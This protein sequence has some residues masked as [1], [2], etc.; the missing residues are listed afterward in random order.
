MQ[1]NPFPLRLRFAARF[2]LL[3]GFCVS[4]VGF[5]QAATPREELLRLVP[6]S[7]GFCLVVQDLRKHAADWQSSPFVEQ[8]RQCPIAVK[9]RSSDKWEKLNQI[10]SE[11]KAKLGLDWKQLRDDI[12]GDAVVLAYR[13]GSPGQPQQ[14]QGVMLLRARNEKVLADLIERVNKVQKE[15]GEL[16]DLT[17]RRHNGV[18]YY[19]RL[20]YDKCT[21]RAPA[22]TLYA[23]HGPILALSAQEDMIRQVIKGDTRSSGGISGGTGETPVQTRDRRDAGPTVSEAERRL[24]ELDAERALL[25][26]WLNPRAFDAEVDAKVANAPA[27]R[28]AAVKQF[29][30][31]WK[32]LESVVFSLS[33]QERDIH[34]SLGVRAR[35]PELPPAARRLFRE[36]ATA[37]DVW[38]RLPQSALFAAGGRLDGAAVLDVLG[39][40]LTP[41]GRKALHATLN[42]PF[43]TLLAEED[44]SANLLPVLGPDWGLC[45]SAPAIGGVGSH[46]SRQ[47]Q[48]MPHLLF[49]L[50][51]DA[52]RNK[53]AP[54]RTLLSALDFA[55]RFVI[56]AHNNEHPDSPLAL[57]TSAVHGQ[58]VRYLTGENGLPAGVQPAYGLLDG[59]LVLASSL[60]SMNRFVQATPAPAAEAPVPLLRISFKDWR[61][62]LTAHR[63]AVVQFFIEH[64]KLSPDAA[65]R[66]LDGLLAALQF[67]ERAEL[68]QRTTS[69][70]VIF[71]LS[72]RTAHA[73]KK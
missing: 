3:C 19:R 63:E 21:P 39:S 35:V 68:S 46:P 32:A 58:E 7:V 49:A 24:H 42:R 33:P 40:F 66:Q 69:G 59:Y 70:Q 53:K 18:V 57:K 36:A 48:A 45:V 14:E 65:G 67:V 64:D 11:M 55:A 13:P 9:I 34:L 47:N 29:A 26:L 8:L 52:N 1:V 73:L 54:E 15:E 37:S 6:D 38:R 20:E 44:F 17:E 22:P 5:S 56:F 71:T 10:E 61:S 30:L 43:A 41:Q 12:L 2:F 25:A 60:E 28:S 51:V 4:L 31:Y 62:Y 16:K 50:R 72:V 23:V 27:E